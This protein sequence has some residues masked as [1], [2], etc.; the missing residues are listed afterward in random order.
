MHPHLRNKQ[1]HQ[2]FK[3]I[4]INEDLY[5]SKLI[6]EIPIDIENTKISEDLES[7]INFF[8]MDTT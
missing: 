7:L 6:N 8:Y 3:Q 5:S 4:L 2:V 1:N